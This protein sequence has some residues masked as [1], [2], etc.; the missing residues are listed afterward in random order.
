MHCIFPTPTQSL[1]PAGSVAILSL[2]QTSTNEVWN[3]S[4]KAFQTPA[5]TTTAPVPPVG[6]SIASYNGCAGYS[7]AWD[8]N[9]PP[10]ALNDSYVAMLIDSLAGGYIAG[11]FELGTSTSD[12]G[13]HPYGTSL[14]YPS[15]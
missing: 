5:G 11:P 3:P 6:I 9:V 15:R 12:P 14:D 1:I 13:E 8:F 4:A 2:T 10:C 7:Y